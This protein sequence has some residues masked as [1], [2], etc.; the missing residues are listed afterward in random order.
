MYERRLTRILVLFGV[1]LLG[2]GAR[3][4]ALQV[5]QVGGHLDRL[6]SRL[7]PVVTVQPRRGEVLWRDGDPMAANEPG[8][9]VYVD[10]AQFDE[11]LLPPG[12]ALP[13]KGFA[14]RRAEGV[15]PSLWEC[16]SCGTHSKR[17]VHPERC[18]RCRSATP[19]REFDGATLEEFA[20]VIGT[21]RD[22]AAS[23]LRRAV[24]RFGDAPQH[25]LHALIHRLD[26]DAA[27]TLRLEAARFPGLVIRSTPSRRIDPLARRIVGGAGPPTPE[28]LERLTSEDRELEG[29]HRYTRAEVFGTLVGRSG[30]ERAFDETL[31]GSPG[32]ALRLRGEVGGFTGELEVLR[33]VKD[34][35]TLRTTLDR[36]VQRAAQEVVDEAP[37]EAGAVV[38]DL[39]DGAVVAIASKTDGGYHQGVTLAQPGSVFK[40]VTALAWLEGGGDPEHTLDCAKVGYLPDG[41]QRYHCEGYHPEIALEL[42]FAKSCNYYF[43]M[44]ARQAGS[45]ALVDACRR[46]G[47]ERN[48]RLHLTGSRAGLEASP[49][50]GEQWKYRDVAYVGIGQGPVDLSPLQVALAFGR[51]ATGGKKLVPFILERERPA[52][53]EIDPVIA[54]H[55]ALLN[56]AA[57]RVV[58][59]GTGRRIDRLAVLHA[60][61]KSGT[62]EVIRR[63][64]DPPGGRLINNA[65]F[66]GYAPA[67]EPRY[68]AAVVFKRVE[69]HGAT[70]VGDRAARLLEAALR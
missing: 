44:R 56:R 65:W 9:S 22:R 3:A 18:S 17:S 15:V 13:R 43:M 25:R 11:R 47:L 20:G 53:V 67:D 39:R 30:L 10:F 52:R 42:A 60:S 35:E 50:L 38:I 46:L 70:E 27:R 26:R 58:T 7:H 54:R 59:E 16:E 37:G 14:R 5:L 31:R 28:N 1:V 2:I 55:A 21:S 69:G 36:R 29:L 12:T 4:F 24:E 48:P 41:K 8:Y 45:A 34:G 63:A 32:L 23:T 33:P 62:A 66:V 68:A 57:R 19:H 51:V 64:T 49:G 61:G 6:E 40:L